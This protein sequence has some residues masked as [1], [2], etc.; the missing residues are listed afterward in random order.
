MMR[1]YLFSNSLRAI[2]I[3]LDRIDR[4][5]PYNDMLL[6]QHLNANIFNCKSFTFFARSIGIKEAVN[7]LLCR[8]ADCI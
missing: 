2:F 1:F 8:G 3:S 5:L 7:D 4:K 6:V